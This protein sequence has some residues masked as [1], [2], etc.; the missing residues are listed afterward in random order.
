M[1][2]HTVNKSSTHSPAFDQCLQIV[3][4][5]D[6]LILIEDG[7]YNAITHRADLLALTNCY[8]LADDVKARGLQNIIDSRFALISYQQFVELVISK[9]LSQSWF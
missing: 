4:P 8:L 1:I 6:N 9:P 5:N 7:V 2:T 3:Q